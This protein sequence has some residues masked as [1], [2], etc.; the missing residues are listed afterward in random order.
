MAKRKAAQAGGDFWDDEDMAQD[1]PQA[2]E[3]GTPAEPES[4]EASAEDVSG[5]LL[6]S[7]RKINRRKLKSKENEK[8]NANNGDAP[9][10]LSKKEK[11]KLKKLK[12]KKKKE[13]AQRRRPSKQQEGT[14][15]RG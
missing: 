5:E 15:Q 6:S 13:L 11:E 1:Q 12:N 3:F 2:E 14:N 4:Q 9:K 8:A 10:L 7:I